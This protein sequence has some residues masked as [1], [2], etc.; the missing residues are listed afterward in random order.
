ML[1]LLE[2]VIFTYWP[3][4]PSS[5]PNTFDYSSIQVIYI[6]HILAH[7][8]PF[9]KTPEGFFH[10]SFAICSYLIPI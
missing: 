4:F 7:S 6:A 3:S 5:S 2:V 9:V 8:S 1:Q 10:L